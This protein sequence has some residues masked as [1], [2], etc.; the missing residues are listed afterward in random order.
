LYITHNYR[1]L[2]FAYQHSSIIQLRKPSRHARDSELRSPSSEIQQQHSTPTTSSPLTTS[3][4][5][6]RISSHNWSLQCRSSAAHHHTAITLTITRRQN[7]NTTKYDHP[8]PGPHLRT[9]SSLVQRLKIALRITAGDLATVTSPISSTSSSAYCSISTTMRAGIQ[10]K[11]SLRS[12]Y[13]C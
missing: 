2:L 10:S 3:V 5:S 12:R 7:H 6:Y 13:R 9:R 1:L 11:H 8:H 4:I